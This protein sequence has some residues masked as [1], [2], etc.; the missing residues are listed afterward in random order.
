MLNVTCTFL[1]IQARAVVF[2]VNTIFDF[3]GDFELLMKIKWYSTLVEGLVETSRFVNSICFSHSCSA[4]FLTFTPYDG[5]YLFIFIHVLKTEEARMESNH[6]NL[7]LNS[8]SVLIQYQIQ[9]KT[10]NVKCTKNEVGYTTPQPTLCQI[11]AFEVVLK[12]PPF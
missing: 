8:A 5:P 9:T 12:L 4:V 6:G 3:W 7:I 11:A 10:N 1:I 2:Y